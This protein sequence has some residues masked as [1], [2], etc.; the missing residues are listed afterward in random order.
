[1][2]G[3][4]RRHAGGNGGILVGRQR[5][6]E[7]GELGLHFDTE[8]LVDEAGG[9]FG[10]RSVANIGLMERRSRSDRP[11]V[12]GMEPPEELLGGAGCSS[13]K[14]STSARWTR[15]SA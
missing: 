11:E 1:M 8:H 12:S 10:L 7:G 4:V 14:A 13:P 5:T 15:R 6:G 3:G 9:E 2:D